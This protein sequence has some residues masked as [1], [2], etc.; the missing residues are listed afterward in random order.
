MIAKN[1]LDCTPLHYALRSHS[2][3]IVNTLLRHNV[4]PTEPDPTDGSTAL[5]H[6]AK[7]FSSC[8]ISDWTKHFRAFLARGVDINSRNSFDETALFG[9]VATPAFTSQRRQ[10]SYTGTF[11]LF[12]EAGADFKMRN[13]KNE[14]L[15]HRLAGIELDGGW[16]G[17]EE[18]AAMVAM[19]RNLL[20]KG[21]DPAWEDEKQRTCLDVAAAAANQEVLKL[22]QRK[23]IA[24]TGSVDEAMLNLPG[25]VL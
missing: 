16:Q 15:L 22:F 5:H 21:C 8:H 2:L 12:E 1:T 6:I 18:R 23:T 13:D 10:P 19:F 3:D 25:D 7:A 20:E 4:D 24:K 17:K 11:P 14:R 9:F